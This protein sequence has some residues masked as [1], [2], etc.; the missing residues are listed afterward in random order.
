MSELD[1]APEESEEVVLF[2]FAAS[3]VV[4]LVAGAGLAI[5]ARAGGTALLIAVAVVQALVLLAVCFGLGV[6]GRIGAL[7]LGAAAALAADI[8]VSVWPH[9]RLG[10]LLAVLGL[11]IPA[12]I[13]HQLL[14]GPARSGVLD[15]LGIVALLA[16]AEVG[17]PGLVQLRHEFLPADTANEVVFA[18]VL[19][20]T[21]ALVVGFL[22]DLVIAVP[23]F[24]VDVPRGLLG[25]LASAGVG[26]AVGYLTLREVDAFAASRGAFAGVSLAALA[27]LLAVAVSF[28]EAS[29]AMPAPGLARR[30][31]P[32]LTALLPFCV[33]APL[34]F[35]LCLAIRV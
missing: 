2:N 9:S 23:R 15:S 25:V 22:V 7:V 3:A 32:L 29:V 16:L 28:A 5:G 21:A 26:A 8:A 11:A 35:L 4:A 14:R 17:L 6:P 19:V 10:T 30:V 1:T 20:V 27:A 33:L 34:A 31:R 24:D 13:G 18:V 12:M